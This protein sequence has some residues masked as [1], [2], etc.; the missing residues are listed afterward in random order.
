M[1]YTD[2]KTSFQTQARQ[3]CQM[4]TISK[5]IMNKSLF[6][7]VAL[8]SVQQNRIAEKFQTLML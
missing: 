6:E 4:N 8:V 2:D 3:E 5:A 1:N 7:N